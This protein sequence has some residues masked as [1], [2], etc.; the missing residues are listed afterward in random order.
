MQTPNLMD[1]NDAWNTTHVM[2]RG[3]VASIPRFTLAVVLAHSYKGD[4]AKEAIES[5]LHE[6]NDVLPEP[7]PDVVITAFDGDRPRLEPVKP[8]P[9]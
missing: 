3:F 6:T 1:M 2:L 4:V 7:K 9:Q 8:D 5:V